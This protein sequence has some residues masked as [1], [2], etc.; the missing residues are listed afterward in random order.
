MLMMSSREDASCFLEGLVRVPSR[1]EAQG[2]DRSRS[3]DARR[4]HGGVRPR[5]NNSLELQIVLADTR[6]GTTSQRICAARRPSS[7]STCQPAFGAGLSSGPRSEGPKGRDNRRTTC[8]L[9]S[10]WTS[11]SRRGDPGGRLG[12]CYV[13]TSA[14]GARVWR[15]EV[16]LDERACPAVQPIIA[17]CCSFVTIRLSRVG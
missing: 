13:I 10:A 2:G 7:A 16:A 6:T 14:D 15:V 17:K 8:I 4:R 11:A 9:P 1:L 3:P 12:R 5:A